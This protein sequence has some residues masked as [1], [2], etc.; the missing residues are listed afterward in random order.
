MKS[1]L[2]YHYAVFRH[3]YKRLGRA[4]E[5]GVF[6]MGFLAIIE[7]AATENDWV[8]LAC[9]TVIL[10]CLAAFVFFYHAD[11]KRKIMPD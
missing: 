8:V 11:E 5:F 3:K 6:L 2:V 4:F 9:F 1:S 10:S 7:L